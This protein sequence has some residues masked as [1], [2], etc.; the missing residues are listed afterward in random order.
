MYGQ[1]VHIDRTTRNAYF[2]GYLINVPYYYPSKSMA[3]VSVTFSGSTF[4][5]FNDQLVTVTFTTSGRLCI[6]IPDTPEFFGNHTLCGVI[7]NY[8]NNYKNDVVYS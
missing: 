2:N 5:V 1:K 6:E 3:Q 8:D 4:Y 7:G